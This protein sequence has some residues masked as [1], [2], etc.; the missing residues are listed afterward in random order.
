MKLFI[1]WGCCSKINC[2]AS[3]LSGRL[4]DGEPGSRAAA[5]KH[6]LLPFNSILTST[7][8]LL[9]TRYKLE[10][11]FNCPKVKALFPL[12]VVIKAAGV[13]AFAPGLRLICYTRFDP[14]PT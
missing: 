9:M 14:P 8:Y 13:C 4:I 1:V 12:V 3:K 5:R 10:F 11:F 6:T 2:E 7:H